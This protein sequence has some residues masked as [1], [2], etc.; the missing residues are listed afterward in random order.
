MELKNIG[1]TKVEDIRPEKINARF[2]GARKDKLMVGKFGH[3]M[4]ADI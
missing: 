1:F 4:K 3:L 2:F